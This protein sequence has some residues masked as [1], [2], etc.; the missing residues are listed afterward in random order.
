MISRVNRS[1]GMEMRESGASKEEIL[2]E[3][4]E[5]IASGQCIMI[6]TESEGDEE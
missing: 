3:V 2:G 6:N 1:I 4:L 5:A